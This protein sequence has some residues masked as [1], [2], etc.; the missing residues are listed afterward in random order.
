MSYLIN[1]NNIK[2]GDSMSRKFINKDKSVKGLKT[3]TK[4][5]GEDSV[6]ALKEGNY[7]N[8]KLFEKF[9]FTFKMFG[10]V[11][12]GKYKEF[13]VLKLILSIIALIYVVSPVDLIPD[14]ILG[15]GWIDDGTIFVLAWN[16]IKK[17]VLKYKL[18]KE[19]IIEIIDN[20]DVFSE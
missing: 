9:K 4:V 20:D 7:E 17:D 6:K 15:L 19:S 12:T 8:L 13:S 14:I 2:L 16:Y 1:I 11:F 3:A 18:W 5:I 10:D